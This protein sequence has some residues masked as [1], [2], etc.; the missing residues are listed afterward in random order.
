VTISGTAATKVTGTP[1]AGQYAV[2][3]AVGVEGLYTFAAANAGASVVLSYVVTPEDLELAVLEHVAIRYGR[4]GNAGQGAGSASG[5][6]V[7][8]SDAS[9]WRSILD[10]IDRYRSMGIG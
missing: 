7:S 8:Y 1:T 2:S 9:D 6:S 4:R 3:T 10:T 5:E